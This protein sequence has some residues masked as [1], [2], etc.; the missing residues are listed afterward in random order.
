MNAL[1][2]TQLYTVQREVAMC[3][4]LGYLDVREHPDVLSEVC[5]IA[6]NLQISIKNNT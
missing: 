6:E 4:E 1:S 5:F 2:A 3:L